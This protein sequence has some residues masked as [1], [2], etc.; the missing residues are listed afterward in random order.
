MRR[1][2][3]AAVV[4]ALVVGAAAVW[5]WRKI[6]YLAHDAARDAARSH[7]GAELR[8][9]TV[10]VAPGAVTMR[11]VELVRDGAAVTIEEIVVVPSLRDLLFGRK[12]FRSVS[13]RGI[14]LDP[15][16]VARTSA[17]EEATEVESEP[18]DDAEGV[19]GRLAD[20]T[21][22]LERLGDLLSAGGMVEIA[23]VRL[24]STPDPSL[25]V[26]IAR[27]ERLPGG[28]RSEGRVE[29]GGG[30]ATWQLDVDPAEVHATG[31]LEVRSFPLAAL[32]T[33]FPHLPWH[34]DR[35]ARLDGTV[36]IREPEGPGPVRVEGRL[37]LS[38]LWLASKRVAE[39]PIG[40]IDV[41]VEGRAEWDLAAHTFDVSAGR[42]SWNGVAVELTGSLSP[43]VEHYLVDLELTFPETRCDAAVGAIPTAVLGELAAFSWTGTIAG[44]GRFYVDAENLDGTEIDVRLDNRCEFA[45]IPALADLARFQGEFEHVAPAAEGGEVVLWTGPGTPS[46][47]P[48]SR[49]SPFLVHAVLAHEDAGFFE[50]EGFAQYAIED[51]LA[52]NLERRRFAFG[53]STISMQL[54]RNL[55]LTRDKTLARKVREVLLTW[56]LEDRLTKPEILELYLNVIEYGPNVY[57]VRSAAHRYF[58]CEPDELTLAQATY[59]ATILPAPV[60]FDRNNYAAGALTA[61]TREQMEFLVRHMA[62]KG[63]VTHEA[64]EVALAE[65][66]DFA[67]ERRPASWRPGMT[68]ELPIHPVDSGWGSDPVASDAPLEG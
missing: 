6:P 18:A 36:T 48:L 50:H 29:G 12:R 57:G 45:T 22:K 27:L 33:A 9:Q 66:A 25:V 64:S 30:H 11:G 67:W 52:K 7:L 53:A 10:D 44:R 56:W 43:S 19:Q 8:A 68:A 46:W 41:E 31:D 34:D 61:H 23:D 17:G 60:R 15:A 40:P 26:E 49:I 35:T 4:V 14:R 16:V 13:A 63:R 55:F 21:R 5:A 47:T 20:A 58:G 62:K 39:R 54:A 32:A 2:V 65:I 51:A 42:V 24:A 1:G 28:F 59:L 38:D 37:T 3:A